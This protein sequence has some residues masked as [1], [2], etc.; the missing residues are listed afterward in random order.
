MANT[1]L[2]PSVFAQEGLMQLE[3]ELVLGN[4]V[5]TDHSKEFAMKG[6]TINIRRPTQYQGQM[7]NLDVTSYSE[8]IT[9]G[10]T[11]IVMD[12]TMTIKMDVG[13]IDGTLSFDRVQEDIIR[14]A[15]IKMRDE[16]EV[17]LASLYTNL[18]HF[19]GT[20]GTV[21]STF[22]SLA[23]GGAIMTDGA[24]PQ[25]D[26]FAVHGT[27]AT[28]ELADGLKGVFV[29]DK[30]K[31]AFEQAEIGRYGG[32]MNYESVHA[33]THVVGVATGTPLV[34]GASQNVTYAA[35]KDTWSQTLNT[36]GWTN[37]TTGILKAGDVFTI[38]GVNAVNPISKADTGRLQTFTVLADADSGA[39]TGPAALTISPPIITDGA[40]KT[41][42]AVPADDAVITV[43]TGASGAI[44]KQSLLLHPKA[45]ALVS[46]PLKVPAGAGVKTS[47]KSGNKVTI[48]CTEWVDGNTLQ[49][50][51]R[52]D[53]LFGVKC[54]DPR[55]GARLTN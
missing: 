12:K 5:H 54:L 41:V 48:S 33:P 1:F 10:K 32:F 37:S 20:A 29:Q 9:Q 11:T 51:F 43:K 13:A 39:S 27:D 18:Y 6:D 2:T 3:N 50:N 53:M 49:H 4:K 8:D 31:T 42:T 55:L 34:N 16:I 22:K 24:V 26:R 28:V 38:A 47:T 19:T 23:Q 21:P 52:F 46:R 36:N 30:A 44:H 7:D 40:Y 17:N 45:F 15:V 35:S 14:P 25:S